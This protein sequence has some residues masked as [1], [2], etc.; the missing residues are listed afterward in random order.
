MKHCYLL[1]F[2][3]ILTS[4]IFTQSFLFKNPVD[5]GI[6]RN[7][8]L[9]SGAWSFFSNPSGITTIK[10]PSAGIGYSSGF[11]IKELASK[12]AFASIPTSYFTGA[13][14]FTHFGFQNFNMQQY[15]LA[16]A[17]QL[18]PW[19]QMG[20]RFN[21]FLRHQT[22]SETFG[23]TTLDAGLQI[24]PDPKVSIGFFTVNPAQV[25]WNL[26]DWEE[27][28]LSAVAAALAYN[29]ASEV[30]LEIGVLKNSDYPPETSFAIEAPV[31]KMV[32][33]RGAAVTNPFR[34]GFGSSLLWQSMGFDIGFN[35]HATLGFSSSFGMMFYLGSFTRSKAERP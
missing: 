32:V 22:G 33:L 30:S 11:H 6:G 21:Y 29:P 14:G 26:H 20:V 9:G 4:P 27:Y 28:Q 24:K 18:A 25:K 16:A 8:A 7:G 13:V 2:L 3:T 10:V 12:A 31:H 5:H 15:S 1:F 19:L 23:I 35:H 34:L 17:R